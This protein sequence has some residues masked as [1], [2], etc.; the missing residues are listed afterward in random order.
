MAKENSFFDGKTILAILVVGIVWFTWERHL[1]KKYPEAYQHKPVQNTKAP[2][3]AAP[4]EVTETTVRVVEVSKNSSPSVPATES[5]VHFEND[6]WSFD[7]SSLGMGLKN[8]TLK[9]FTDRQNKEVVLGSGEGLAPF[10]TEVIGENKPVAFAVQKLADGSFEGRAQIGAATIIKT[11]SIHPTNYKVDTKVVVT[12]A[13]NFKGLKTVVSEKLDKPKETSMFFPN[14]DMQQYL[15]VDSGSSTRETITDKTHLESKTF[16]KVSLFAFGSHYFALAISDKSAII[17]KL[18]L[19][20]NH[21]NHL[22]IGHLSHEVINPAETFEVEYTSFAGPKSLD[23]LASVDPRME[24]VINFGFFGALSRP[25]LRVMKSFYSLFHNWGFAI[26]LLT[27]VV[28]LFVLPFNIMSYKSMK[29][30]QAIQPLLKA[31]NEKHKDDV[32]AKNVATM[33]LMREHKVN[34]LG[35]CLPMLLQL[36]IFF[37]LYQVFGQSIELYKAPF[38]FWIK[39]L[40]LHDPYYVLPVAMAAIMFLQQ[41][42]TP[43]TMDPAQAKVM[44]FVPVLFSVFMLNLPSALNLY[45]FVS[46]LFGILQQ[47]YF[48]RDNTP[49][50]IAKP[51]LA[52]K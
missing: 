46:S 33:N 2:E 37:A 13:Q 42:M 43:T 15:I 24:E 36:P 18:D 5:L 34:P 40:S 47:L 19:Q 25:M 8:I 49:V 4:K 3:T 21:Q 20:W 14:Y 17:P 27:L 28:R 23:I 1:E 50:M 45:I 38:I 26:I 30:M 44:L 16:N 22:M 41:K 51:K 12:G 7:I 10:S 6:T 9:K 31:I 48:M 39:D 32:Q 11:Y 52:E 35:G 29:A